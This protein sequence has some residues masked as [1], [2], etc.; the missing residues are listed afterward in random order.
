[1][2]PSKAP[3]LLA[4]ADC[5]NRHGVR[6]VLIGGFAMAL[7][8]STYASTDTD[9]AISRDESNL[10][11]FCAAANELEAHPLRAPKSKVDPKLLRQPYVNLDSVVG[12]IDLINMLPGID[13]F[14]GMRSRCEQFVIDGI[15]IPC[16]S[17]DD[18]IALKEASARPKDALHVAELHAIRRL[19]S[20]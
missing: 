14:E 4:L 2:L 20:R 1:M 7:H 9:L 11:A 5:L 12:A 6:W 19:K 3:D 17:L 15:M 13:G 18:L 10:T 16:A 8:G